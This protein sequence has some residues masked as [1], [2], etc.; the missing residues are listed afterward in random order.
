MLAHTLLLLGALIRLANTQIDPNS[1]DPATRAAWCL[2]QQVACPLICLQLPGASGPPISNTCDPATLNFLCVCSNGQSPNAS[3]YTMTIPYFI[4]TQTNQNCVA[5]CNGLSTCQSACIQD[6]PCG[7]QNPKRV[8]T[9]TI[10]TAGTSKTGSP[11]GSSS[12]VIFNGFGSSA[13]ATGSSGSGG[14]PTYGLMLELGHLYGLF[15]VIG[16]LLTGVF[17]LL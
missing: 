17:V 1:V 12:T 4:C 5:A 7:A 14:P 10:T 13:T 6:H 3:Q 15:A 2:D 9:S 11:T 16:G 8:N